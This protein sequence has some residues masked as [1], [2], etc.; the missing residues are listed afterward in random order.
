MKA[1]SFTVVQCYHLICLL[2]VALVCGSAS[3]G[4]AQ[5]Y[6]PDD[7]GNTWI[8]RSTDGIDERVVAIEG[9]ETVGAESLKVISDRT[10]DNIS[11]FFIKT[12]PDGVMIF[13]A[14]ASVATFGEISINYS[15]PQTFLPIPLELGSEWTVV[16]EAKILFGVKIAVTNNA[17]VAAVEN[18]IVPA[19]TFRD[20]LKIE[21]E[22]QVG[23]AAGGLQVPP[24]KTTMWLAPDIGLVKAISTDDII[25]ELIRYDISIDGNEVAVQPKGHLAMTWGALKKR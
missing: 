14:I 10:G 20:C 24:Q 22:L 7:F 25:F 4:H 12:E 2:S 17:K 3:S 15:P 16:G 8:L 5:N 1:R 13:R 18:V 19:G 21:Q 23:L 9:P 6:Y 11:K